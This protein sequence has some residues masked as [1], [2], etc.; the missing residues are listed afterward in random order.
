VLGPFARSTT[1]RRK[2]ESAY[3]LVQS[4]LDVLL[5]RRLDEEMARVE[6]SDDELLVRR[7]LLVL[8][9]EDLLDRFV[10]EH[11]QVETHP[12]HQLPPMSSGSEGD[13]NERTR[14]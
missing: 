4:L 2:G 5:L 8:P 9:D 13:E 7:E 6:I 12:V 1:G 3:L 10:A 11:E 14:R